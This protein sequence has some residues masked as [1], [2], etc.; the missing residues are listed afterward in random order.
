MIRAAQ[1]DFKPSVSGKSIS[2]RKGT[3][4][5]VMVSVDRID[6]F[7]G[8]VTFDCKN[9]TPE[10]HATFPITIET[11]GSIF[12]KTTATIPKEIVI[13]GEPKCNPVPFITTFC[14]AYSRSF[15]R[16]LIVLSHHPN[17]WRETVAGL[18]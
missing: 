9:V 4:R 16:I 14:A 5:E 10:G 11:A 17:A 6:G 15:V 3:G 8:P 7:D 12:C 18:C 2:L 1:P 13:R